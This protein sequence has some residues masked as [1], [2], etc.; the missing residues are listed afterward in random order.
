MIE[1]K[2]GEYTNL[3]PAYLYAAANITDIPGR[4]DNPSL[5]GPSVPGLAIDP[6]M[7]DGISGT[8]LAAGTFTFT[9]GKDD[10]YG[11][12]EQIGTFDLNITAAPVPEP[13]PEPIPDTEGVS[14]TVG[15]AFNRT[16][17]DVAASI[18]LSNNSG[19]VYEF[20]TVVSTP[21]PGTNLEWDR[22]SGTVT[23]PGEYNIRVF[24]ASDGALYQQTNY[25][26][27][28]GAP[29]DPEPGEPEPADAT[30]QK[31]LRFMGLE[32]TPEALSTAREHTRVVTT[33]VHGYTRGRG[34]T[35]RTPG[36]DIEDVIISA[37]AR[38]LLNPQQAARQQIG[39][40]SITYASLEG[41]TLAEKAVLHRYRR[42]TA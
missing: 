10:D 7:V 35:G 5:K 3:V 19:A 31:V 4:Y 30:P 41:F 9:I 17:N 28:V 16:A 36:L 34:F 2:V 13:E 8:P 42:R 37:T 18:G 25:R 1:L 21:P 26:V 23:T 33:F 32:A 12:P 38:Y 14:L 11:S 40:Q 24:Y 39:D 6:N 27:R 22:I 15:D 20:D 29:V